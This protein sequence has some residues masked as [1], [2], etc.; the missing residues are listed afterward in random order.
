[1]AS[2]SSKIKSYL[3]REVNFRT[4][5]K[6]QDDS[7]GRGAYIKQWNAAEPQPTEAELSAVEADADASDA[8]IET[9]EARRISYKNVGDQLDMMYWDQANGTNIWFDH[10]SKVK[11]DNPK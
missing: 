8:L 6:L 5:V 3:G 2:L 11:A 1:M 9:L 7:D 4:E 10:I